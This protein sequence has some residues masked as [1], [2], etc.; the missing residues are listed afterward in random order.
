LI[1]RDEARRIAAEVVGAPADDVDR[2]WALKEFDAGWLIVEVAQIGYRGGSTRVIERDSGRVMR[3]PSNVPPSYIIE[4]YDEVV[5]D[6][7]PQDR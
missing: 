6:A 4:R 2:G 5:H 7:R 1:T 3:F